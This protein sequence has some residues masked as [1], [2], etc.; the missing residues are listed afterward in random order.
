MSD[1]D[2]I[3]F[4]GKKLSSLMEEVYNNHQRKN[5][6]IN[7]LIGELKPLIGDIGDATLVVPLLKEYLDA[8][9][10]NDDLLLKLAALAQKTV[11]VPGGNSQG[12]DF[13]ISEEEKKALLKQASD[14]KDKYLAENN[15]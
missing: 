2:K 12:G 10:K 14:L 6:Q 9:I 11:Q 7:T 4:K 3:V 15:G 5:N 1:L 8:G 13:S